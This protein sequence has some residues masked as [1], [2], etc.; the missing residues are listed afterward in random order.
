MALHPITDNPIELPLDE[1]QERICYCGELARYCSLAE[2]DEDGNPT[3]VSEY[4]QAICRSSKCSFHVKWKDH[5]HADHHNRRYSRNQSSVAQHAGFKD[6]S[7][8]GGGNRIGNEL[9]INQFIN[10]VDFKTL[11]EQSVVVSVE[12][13][14]LIKFEI[15]A[16]NSEAVQLQRPYK[17][18]IRTFIIRLCS[19]STI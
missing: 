7:V 13:P 19:L 9:I 18:S 17:R 1:R 4:R 16:Q 2:L 8:Q 3:W 6:V 11:Q 10:Q 14:Q 5:K 12:W 15:V